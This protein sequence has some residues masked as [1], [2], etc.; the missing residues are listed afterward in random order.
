[1]AARGF[2]GSG[3]V[4]L[5]IFV[6]G[7]STGLVGPFEAD[8]FE[9]KANSELKERTSKGKG[10]YGQITA[11]AAIPKPFDLNLTLSEADKTGLA[12]ALLGTAEALTQASGTL[13]A[14]DVTSKP[15]VW[16][17]IGKGKVTLT[18]VK[19]HTGATTYTVG[20]DY[21]LNSELGLLKVLSTG[22]I[23]ANEVVKVTGSYAA[24]SGSKIRGNV[25][26]SIRASV[27]FDGVN[28]AD[29]RPTIVRVPEAVFA[30]DAAVDLLGDNFVDVPLKG[31]PVTPAGY[32]EPFTIELR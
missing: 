5:D 19:D 4:Y 23:P 11:S 8:K 10:R 21:L 25:Q 17:P 16:V 27:V 18:S 6:D 15:D 14:A 30:S 26:A 20:T 24:I 3:D 31:R 2:L 28:L 29:D 22:T 1:M 13:T 9:L 32:N 12:I 7:V